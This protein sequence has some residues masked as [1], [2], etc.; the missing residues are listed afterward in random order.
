MTHVWRMRRWLPERF[1][2]ACRV[3]TSGRGPG[4]RNLLVEFADGRRVVSSR[5]SIRCRRE[6]HVL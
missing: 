6:N 2:Q 4:P 1:G 5:W 3:V